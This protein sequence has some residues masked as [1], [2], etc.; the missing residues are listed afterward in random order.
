MIAIVAHDNEVLDSL[1]RWVME[2]F[3][4]KLDTT[5]VNVVRMV[6]HLKSSYFLLGLM[7]AD[8]AVHSAAPTCRWEQVYC[9]VYYGSAPA[10]G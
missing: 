4:W 6:A 5:E 3:G 7:I 9:Q 1:V 10:G 2:L 8:M